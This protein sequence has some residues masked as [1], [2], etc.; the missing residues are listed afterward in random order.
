[1]CIAQIDCEKDLSER[2]K[3][4]C[5]MV[6]QNGMGV[7]QTMLEGSSEPELAESY[8][9]EM[10][11]QGVTAD[12][13]RAELIRAK[14]LVKSKI[15]KLVWFFQTKNILVC[16]SVL[17]LVEKYVDG[18]CTNCKTRSAQLVT[19]CEHGKLCIRCFKDQ[20]GC[21]VAACVWDHNSCTFLIDED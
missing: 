20:S 9:A 3:I 7:I 15:N 8:L 18:L 5:S 14:A 13:F 12:N 1:M 21:G 11:K 4:F 6:E 10:E 17:K 19:S 16:V 2:T